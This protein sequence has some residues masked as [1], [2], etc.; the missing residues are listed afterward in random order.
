METELRLLEIL[1]KN[2]ELFAACIVASR[3]LI[4]HTKILPSHIEVARDLFGAT[5]RM[6]T[7]ES[8]R[9]TGGTKNEVAEA[10]HLGSSNG[11]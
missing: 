5:L 7:E 4:E 10:G 11:V 1:S 2:E 3:R 8:L 9:M 6:Y